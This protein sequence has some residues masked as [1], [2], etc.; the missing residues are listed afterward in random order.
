MAETAFLAA[1]TLTP[2]GTDAAGAGGGDGTGYPTA[3]SQ[4]QQQQRVKGL[5]RAKAAQQ[6]ERLRVLSTPMDRQHVMKDLTKEEI[7]AMVELAYWSDFD[8]SRRDAASAFAT[9]SMNDHNID[10]LDR[11][12]VLGAV[13]ALIAR[14]ATTVQHKR[15]LS[16]ASTDCLQDASWCL[17]RMLRRDDIKSRFLEAPGGL[18]NVLALT[19]SEEVTLRQSAVQILDTLCAFPPA[20]PA[21]LREGGA[22]VLVA[23]LASDDEPL[24]RTAA[25]VVRG[26]SRS[27]HTHPKSLMDADIVR[28]LLCLLEEGEEPVTQQEEMLC[29]AYFTKVSSDEETCSELADLGLSGYLIRVLP[30]RRLSLQNRLAMLQALERMTNSQRCEKRIVDEG[31]F[32]ALVSL[33]FNEVAAF[34]HGC[35]NYLRQRQEI[36]GFPTQGTTSSKPKHTSGTSGASAEGG[37]GGGGGGGSPHA[38]R[39]PRREDGG[40]RAGGG[41]GLLSSSA[42]TSRGMSAAAGAGGRRRKEEG[43]FSEE[44]LEV[45]MDVARTCLSVFAHLAARGHGR[46]ALHAG[47]LAHINSVPIGTG[48]DPHMTGSLSQLVLEL[49]KIANDNEGDRLSFV[50]QGPLDAI[51]RC[52]KGGRAQQQQCA[53]DAL[54]TVCLLTELKPLVFSE[55]VLSEVLMLAAVQEHVQSAACVLYQFSLLPEWRGPLVRDGCL[56]VLVSAIAHSMGPEAPSVE[57]ALLLIGPAVAAIRQITKLDSAGR[58]LVE[59]GGLP[60]LLRLSRS[61]SESIRHDASQALKHIGHRGRDKDRDTV[62]DTT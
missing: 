16:K 59:A 6:R 44:K 13:L 50:A 12:G 15:S 36:E 5:S 8:T 3:A 22:R 42:E 32:E 61:D 17:R 18:T 40:G 20:Q 55:E 49:S 11:A 39:H 21:I 43:N 37:G 9:L 26:L 51:L 31:L 33:C 52:L 48:D 19:A 30:E 29:I 41:G 2:R 24:R 54:T 60:Q 23:Q 45:A 28:F 27:P 34:A 38:T 7:H 25:R 1:P 58:V 56:E 4:Q 47:V 35:Q 14:E 46:R 53:L 10:V 62:R 57:D